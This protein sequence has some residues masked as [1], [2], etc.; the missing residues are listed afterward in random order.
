M[1]VTSSE[2][3]VQT[4]V[5]AANSAENDRKAFIAKFFI[6]QILIIVEN[7]SISVKNWQQPCRHTSLSRCI[8]L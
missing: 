6:R 5:F 2:T 1:N 4:L 7:P 8:Q 3:I